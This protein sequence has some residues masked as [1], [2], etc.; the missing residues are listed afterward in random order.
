MNEREFE[1]NGKKFQLSKIDPF[2]QFAIVR[3]L[4]PILG[5]II[6]IAQKLGLKKD[7]SEVAKSEEQTLKEIGMLAQP[8]MNGLSK[9][10]DDDANMVLLGLCS[11]VALWQPVH[12]CWGQ[13]SNGKQLMFQDLELPELLQIAGRAFTFNLTGFFNS[14]HRTS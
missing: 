11:A 8:I 4:A 14:A 1:V 10:S 3:R 5:D 7:S 12:N 13:V 9:L 6:P 2:K